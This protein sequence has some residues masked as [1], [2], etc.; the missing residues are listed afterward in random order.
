M[1][2]GQGAWGGIPENAVVAVRSCSWLQ[3]RRY[4]GEEWDDWFACHP[5]L[6]ERIL[7]WPGARVGKDGVPVVHRS[8][9]PL[10]EAHIPTQLLVNP[11]TTNRA[12]AVGM[13]P[14]P[15]QV[16]GAAFLRGRRGALI[17]D[18]MRLGKTL[19]VAM[20]YDLSEGPLVVVGPLNVR[21]VWTKL[22]KQLWPEV[23]ATVLDGREYDVSRLA[24]A[25]L[26][27]VHYDVVPAWRS[28]GWRKLGLLVMEEAH[29]LSNSRSL[30][31]QAIFFMALLARRVIAVTGTPLWN[32]P[33]G[34]FSILAAVNPGAWG[35]WSTFAARYCSG[36]RGAF[37]FQTGEPSNVEEF[38]ARM[39]EV[40]IRRK[41][42]DVRDQLPETKRDIR[43]L[44][45]S[46][47]QDRELT[48]LC[49]ALRDSE[50]NTVVGTLA[51]MRRVLG[52]MKLQYLF[53]IIAP[54][55]GKPFVVWCWHKDVAD[56]IEATLESRGLPVYK[57]TGKTSLYKSKKTGEV[58]R[59]A[60][61]D[62]WREDPQGVLVCNIAVGQVGI[63]LS[64]AGR[65]IFA[66]LD[67]TPAT[68]A[69]AEMR[70]FTPEREMEV[71]YL[72]AHHRVDEEIIRVLREKFETSNI[73]G[74]PAA[75]AAVDVLGSAFGLEDEGDVNRLMQAIME[76]DY[77]A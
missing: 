16:D 17:V 26:V 40:M 51:R 74:V 8:H 61:L 21:P 49:N 11:D 54:W 2:N 27:Y 3:D 48:F 39:T 45:L 69:Q 12:K 53:E 7:A 9:L 4:R 23:E 73:M 63:D 37:G 68:I 64:H 72:A 22:F 59:E 44:H 1:E 66:E 20:S 13:V 58:K 15:Y 18:E 77:E 24:S 35:N 65:A 28:F 33:V 75:D 6:A 41:W 10:L 56:R 70:T 57:V 31:S 62:K 29:L 55:F 46:P 14:R 30:R 42:A 52:E 5:T 50:T 34:M 19:Q 60:I 38:R 76:G 67:F 32:Q 71:V 47:D 25:Q 36:A 43:V